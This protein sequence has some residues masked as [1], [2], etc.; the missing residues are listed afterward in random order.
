MRKRRVVITGMGAVSPCGIGLPALTDALKQERCCLSVLSEELRIPGMDCCL[1]GLVPPIAHVKQIPREL[2]RGMSPMSVFA[3]LAA[4]EALALAGFPENDLPRM[5]VCMGS[6]LGS[7]QELQALFTSFISDGN[8]DA[9]R[10]MSFFKIMSHTASTALAGALGL[11][12][13][14]LNPTA[15]CAAGLQ[16]VGM[17]YEA[18]AFGREDRMLCGGAEEYSPLTTATFDKIGAASHASDPE[19]GSRPFDVRR[20]G[21]VCS[22][23]AG[24]LVLEEKELAEARG[25]RI[26]AEIA[27]FA[28]TSSARDIAQPSREATIA[29]MREALEDAGLT[30]GDIA[31]VNAH[32][33]ATLAGDVAESH[34]IASVWGDTV[35]VSSLKGILGHA[36]AASGALEVIA[37]AD[38]IRHG[39]RIGCRSDIRPDPACGPIYLAP[40]AQQW[41]A[42][43]II[44]NSFALGGVYASLV[45]RPACR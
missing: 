15:A 26:I 42:G 30:P 24:V 27:G 14:L 41:T 10:T 39:Y 1:A 8:L 18:I 7:G 28:T 13:R 32:A 34:A 36:M 31:Y 17:A 11:S 6:T 19:Q 5:G 37:C 38:M 2:R 45:L 44:K 9:V 23:G 21:I 16:G 12:G 35:P 29:C 40:S 43:P 33:T 25:A 20:D 4:K 22:E 3:L